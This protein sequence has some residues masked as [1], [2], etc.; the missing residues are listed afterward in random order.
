[1]KI[2]YVL[3]SNTLGGMEKHVE[4]LIKG[5][6]Y[7]NHIVYV[8]CKK[9]DLTSVYNK[10]GA[11]VFEQDPINLDIDIKYIKKLITFLRQNQIDLVHSHELK[12][13]VNTLISAFFAKT[14]VKVTHTH[15]PISEWQTKS[16]FKKIL[17]VPTYLFYSIMINIFSDTE[18]ALTQSRK[19]V[20]ISEGIN[21]NKL[22]VIFNSLDVSQF[23]ISLK[24]KNIYKN[25]IYKKYDL[26]KD[27]F[28]I[29]N[30]GR[31]TIEKGIDVLI[32]AFYEFINHPL[33]LNKPFYL[34]LA[35][36][37]N[38]ESYIKDLIFDL[39][40]ESKVV[41]TGVFDEKDKIKYYSLI[42]L[43]VFPT[44]AEGFGIVLMEAMFS[45]LPIVCS[46]LKVLN[47]VAGDTVTYFKPKDYIDLSAKLD[48]VYKQII[49]KTYNTY[50]SKQLV[51]Q[52]YSFDKFINNYQNLYLNLMVK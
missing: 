41:L 30:V 33:N 13:V 9:G 2:L 14:K 19:K 38:L 12:A 52:N 43:F 42:D 16:I 48:F 23:D 47:E 39:N 32:K 26:P 34:L 37:G 44:L 20:K 25:E 7:N 3:N 6:V 5:M 45:E 29:G 15:T 28:V 31:L 27:A 4:D 51:L 46:N 10:L 40:I 18:I 50:L 17:L 1:M 8:W 35:G 21:P 49:D 24:Q 22:Q 11:K 36:G